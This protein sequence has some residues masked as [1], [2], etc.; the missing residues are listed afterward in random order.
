MSVQAI[1]LPSSGQKP[2]SAVF[3]LTSKAL[4]SEHLAWTFLNIMSVS[5][6]TF[7]AKRS[8]FGVS[9]MP[10]SEQQSTSLSLARQ[11][12]AERPRLVCGHTLAATLL[13]LC[14]TAAGQGLNAKGHRNVFGCH[15]QKQQANVSQEESTTR[16][17]QIHYGVPEK[18]ATKRRK[19]TE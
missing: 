9:Q 10:T 7:Q 17:L 19:I 13:L 3:R 11:W 14:S 4:G 1:L 16:A 12:T 18:Y 2:D 5:A 15:L 6:R 8:L